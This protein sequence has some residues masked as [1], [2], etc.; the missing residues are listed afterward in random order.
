MRAARPSVAEAGGPFD[1]VFLTVKGYDTMDAIEQLKQDVREGRIGVDRLIDV[2]DVPHAEPQPR[3]N[4]LALMRD[5]RER[6]D[7]A[8]TC[9]ID[10]DASAHGLESGLALQDHGADRAVLDGSVGLRAGEPG[11]HVSFLPAQ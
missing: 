1:Y 11:Q 7:V 10:N 5:L 3:M 4:A 8:V 2:V 6:D 9:R